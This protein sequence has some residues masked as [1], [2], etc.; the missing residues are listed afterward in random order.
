MTKSLLVMQFV[1][2]DFKLI[3]RND[4]RNQRVRIDPFV[5]QESN[6]DFPV[7]PNAGAGT[8]DLL[9]LE[10][11]FRWCKP[12]EIIIRADTE[13]I[14]ISRLYGSYRRLARRSWNCQRLRSH[15]PR[16]SHSVRRMISATTSGVFVISITISADIFFAISS[17]FGWE[18]DNEKQELP[19]GI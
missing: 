4:H 8:A 16:Q 5:L 2:C 3:Q 15:N 14:P 10:D 19:R 17:R 13:K 9:L 7:M 12:N 1:Q 18:F 11:K 6:G